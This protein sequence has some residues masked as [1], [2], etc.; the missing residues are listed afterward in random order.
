MH[1]RQQKPIISLIART[2][3]PAPEPVAI[4]N[5]GFRYAMDV[6]RDGDSLTLSYRLSGKKRFLP[7]GEVAEAADDASAVSD[8]NYWYLDLTSTAGGTIGGKP[9]E[10]LTWAGLIVGV[11]A[12]IGALAGFASV[13]SM[14]RMLNAYLP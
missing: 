3:R 5:A 9:A 2:A 4:E 14:C 7:A 1:T 10:P 11:L 13:T 12:T 6:A 8:D